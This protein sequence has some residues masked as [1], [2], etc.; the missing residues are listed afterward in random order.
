MTELVGRNTWQQGLTL[1]LQGWQQQRVCS[2]QSARLM[3]GQTGFNR[4]PARARAACECQGWS[5][6]CRPW[7]PFVAHQLV[8]PR[9]GSSSTFVSSVASFAGRKKNAASATIIATFTFAK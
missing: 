6:L 8:S 4:Q 9:M 3:P 2:E 7:V 1:P 5:W